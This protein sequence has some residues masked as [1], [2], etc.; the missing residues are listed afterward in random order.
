MKWVEGKYERRWR[1]SDN[2]YAWQDLLHVMLV[3]L[4]V[5]LVVACA[6]FLLLI[7]MN[8]RVATAG[9]IV[10]FRRERRLAAVVIQS[11]KVTTRF[12][13]PIMV[14]SMECTAYSPTVSECDAAPLITAS[15]QRVR[16]GGIAAD[17][18]V[19][20]FGSIV[21]IPDY[22]NGNPCT[23]IDTGS[24]IKDNKLDVFMYSAHEATHWGR[25]KNV[26]VRV[27]FEPKVTP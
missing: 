7:L 8:P 24:A 4:A 25:R 2:Y 12:S 26:P 19:L 5:C 10:N 11:E 27:L 13:E 18:R 16:A 15:G 17:L 22:N 6:V 20:P 1:H 3:T 23:V 14:L 21:I 9:D